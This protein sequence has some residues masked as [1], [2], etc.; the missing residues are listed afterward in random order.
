M[1]TLT[2][3]RSAYSELAAVSDHRVAV[4]LNRAIAAFSAESYSATN[5][6]LAILAQTALDVCGFLNLSPKTYLATLERLAMSR[7]DTTVVGF[8][9]ASDETTDLAVAADVIQARMPAN[10]RVTRMVGSLSAASSSGSVT[11]IVTVAGVAIGTITILANAV[12]G[13]I[14]ITP[15]TISAGQELAVEITGAGTDAAGL[16]ITLYG[17]NL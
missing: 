6:D 4:A 3:F 8:F 7:P 2:T 13:S 15:A 12:T 14:D 10:A 5:L 1:A 11:A 16:K 9:A 17:V